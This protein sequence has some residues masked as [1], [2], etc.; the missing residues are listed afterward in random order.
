MADA[1]H[2]PM[3]GVVENFSYFECPDCGKQHPVFGESNIDAIAEEM[4]LPVMA[5]LPIM[6]AVAEAADKGCFEKF[7]NKALESA[8]SYIEKL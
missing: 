4:N 6:P 3:L 8:F 5:K 7:E 2:I 1:M